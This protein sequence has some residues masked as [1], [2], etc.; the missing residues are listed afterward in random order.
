M[1]GDADLSVLRVLGRGAFAVVHL[2]QYKGATVAKKE[3]HITD[4]DKSKRSKAVFVFFFIVTPWL[5]K[6]KNL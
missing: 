5:H 2:V 1:V 4:D 3:L 6:L